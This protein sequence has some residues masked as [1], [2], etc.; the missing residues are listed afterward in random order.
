MNLRSLFPQ[1]GFPI[2]KT[3]YHKGEKNQAGLQAQKKAHFQLADEEFE[4]KPRVYSRENG[5]DDYI[6][7]L[8]LS[9]KLGV[10]VHK[11]RQAQIA[12]E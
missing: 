11:G 6:L 10:C 12:A 4:S 8:I 7:S 9:V 2:A 1:E 5:E 3:A